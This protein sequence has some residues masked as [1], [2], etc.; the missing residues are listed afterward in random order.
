[1]FGAMFVAAVIVLLMALRQMRIFEAI[2]LGE[3]T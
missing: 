1:V 3:T 2:K